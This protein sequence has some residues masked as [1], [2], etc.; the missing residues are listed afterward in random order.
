MTPA[1]FLLSAPAMAL[2][3]ALALAPLRRFL[4]H[5]GL[6]DRPNERSSH[7]VPTPRGAGLLVLPLALCAWLAADGFDPLPGRFWIVALAAL[8]LTLFS[9]LDDRRGLAAAPRLAVHALA[10]A[11]GLWALPPDFSLTQGWLPRPAD[12]ALAFAAWLWFL[13]L[14]NFMDGI[15]G[16]TGVEAGSV[17]TGLLLLVAVGALPLSLALPLL[18][19]LGALLG[20]LAWNWHPAA[21]FLGDSGSV[22]LGYLLGWLL[23]LA[24][25]AGLW[26]VA[27]ILPLYYWADATLTLLRRLRRR[28]KFWRAHRQHFY[29]R[30]VGTGHAPVACAI[31]LVNLALIALALWSRAEPGWALAAAAASVALLLGWL[32]RRAAG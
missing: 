27:L 6:V 8:A 18:A 12:L 14:T 25:G 17:A 4:M 1:L 29:Q 28:E 31:L 21:L 9:A 32:A 20:F 3:V 30:A 2:L 10:V 24:A 23:L 13:E 19:L 16:V 26:P 22:P 15:D 11:L 5:A 7:A